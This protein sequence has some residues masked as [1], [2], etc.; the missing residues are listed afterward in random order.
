MNEKNFDNTLKGLK[1]RAWKALKVVFKN[2]LG[3]NKS[4]NYK[5]IVNEP[6]NAYK[7]MECNK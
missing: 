4:V 6:M 1:L 2:I 3:K 7:K 5:H